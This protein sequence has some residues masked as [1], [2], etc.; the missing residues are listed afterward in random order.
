MIEVEIDKDQHTTTSY[1]SQRFR[2]MRDTLGLRGKGVITSHSIRRYWITRF[3]GE[4]NTRDLA[5]RLAGHT[6]TR[7]IDYYMGELIEPETITTIDIGV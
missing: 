2:K 5:S 4:G 6:T 1:Y 7:M 3:V